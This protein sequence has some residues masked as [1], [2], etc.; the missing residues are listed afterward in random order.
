MDLKQVKELVRQN[1]IEFF[2]CSFVEMSGVP[3]AKLVP[4][5]H[6]EDMASEGAG[7]AGFA[8]GEIGQDPHDPDIMA[9]PDFNSLMTLPWRRNTA[10]VAGNVF[11]NGKEWPYAPRNI[12]RRNLE[13]LRK[14]GYTLNIGVEPEF[15]LLKRDGTGPITLADPL[16]NMV[17]PCY[18]LRTLHRNLEL[19]T[20]LIKHMQELGWDP[21]AND[22]ED[23]N[24]QFE[25]N[26][27]YADALTTADRHTFFRWM[28]KV[29]AEQHGLIATFM[30]KPFT[31]LT[32]NGAHYHM[33]LWDALNQTNLFLD[34]KDPNGLSKLAY[35]FI[36]G[37][38]HHAKAIA[39]VTSPIV[40]SYK[41]LIRGAPRSGATWAPVYVTYGGNNRTQMIRIPAAGRIE[42]R[43]IDGAANPYLAC[44]LMIA[45]GLD[46]IENK[47]DPGK[48]NDDNLYEVPEDELQQRGIGFLPTTLDEALGHLERD[49]VLC[50]ALG[51]QYAAYYI[52]VKREEWRQYHR[53]VSPWELDT[54]LGIY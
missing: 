11:V 31:N 40:N 13:A 46:G 38:L 29:A 44:T 21:C 14:K 20:T 36:G 12:L 52:K 28:V 3:K 25:I 42:N 7:F 5:T 26:W 48:C 2:L 45:A 37:V 41:R 54:Y 24:G 47:M 43:V 32:G 8:T 49:E 53:S 6:L 1:G 51:A 39:A 27:R 4:A 50:G 9:L 19:M 10:W 33:S 34:E 23:A 17:K 16:D 15:M 30:P 18:D 35:H 22:H